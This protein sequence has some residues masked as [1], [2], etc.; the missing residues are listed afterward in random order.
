MAKYFNI[1]G[2]CLPGRDYMADVSEKL[3]QTLVMVERGD[4]FIINR[5]RQYG[6]TTLLELL[7][8]HLRKTGEY[9]VFNQSFE[10]IGDIIFESEA[11]FSQRFFHLIARDALNWDKGLSAWMSDRGQEVTDLS[12][13]SEAITDL[14]V[15]TNKKLVLLI[16]EVD[17]S[18][19]NQLFISFIGMLRNKYLRRHLQT[20]LTF[21]SIV[22]AGVHDIKTLKL[23]IRP[24]TDSAK[25]NSPWNIATQFEVDMNLQPDEIR[26]MLEEYMQDRGIE[27]DTIA[28]AEK[29]FSLTSGYPFLVSNLCKITDEKIL[30]QKKEPRWTPEDIETA[31]DLL[32]RD[33]GSNANFD[34]LVKNLENNPE[35]YDLVFKAVIGSEPLEFNSQNPL[36]HL[37]VL[38]GIFRNGE[39]L[40]IHN[41][42]YAEVIANY[43]TSKLATSGHHVHSI[44]ASPYLLPEDR[45]DLK[46]V[47]TKFQDYMKE[48]YSRKDAGFLER[49]G[50][51]IF[52]AFLKPI[53]NGKG[54]A[55]K[56][57]QISEEKRLDIAITFLRHKYVVELKLWYGEAAHKKG[58]AQLSGYL[59]RQQLNEG[60]LV[61]FDH[62]RE[63]TWKKG[64][65]R[66]GG[67]RVFSVWV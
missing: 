65:A 2:L 43:M 7:A 66:T 30:P 62:R 22:L 33:P 34:S 40:R 18:S 17:K 48:E 21:H 28:I 15:H 5:P 41:Q 50:R 42:I 67:K 38:Y 11:V 58:L 64:W 44:G 61:I 37:G 10:G 53:L 39:G 32:V 29:L 51:L 25:Y 45:L 52:L 19:N 54:Y 57:P 1:T 23:K 46:K 14:A 24:E 49:N 56:E 3:R 16:D 55:F 31:A 47:L 12:R 35:L 60:Y 63:K 6:K 59:E 27:M 13:L 8:N 26:G 20:D 9:I 36:I 4:Y